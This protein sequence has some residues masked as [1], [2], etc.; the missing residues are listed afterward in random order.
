MYD[1]L[2]NSI[3]ELVEGEI[4]KISQ[5]I[6]TTD[7]HTGIESKAADNILKSYISDNNKEIRYIVD[8]GDGIDN[9]FMSDFPVD[10]RFVKNAQDEFDLYAQHWK[11]LNYLVPRAK[12]I[13]IPGNHDK[14]R[15]DK[16]KNMK[17]GLACL[18]NLQYESILKEAIR[19]Q[20]VKL[21]NFVFANQNYQIQ[22]TKSNLDTFAHG[23]PRLDP[24]VKCGITGPRRTAMEYPVQ[25][26]IYIGHGHQHI[27]FPRRQPGKHLVMIAGMFDIEQ[28]KKMY[29]SWHPYTNGFGVIKY[30]KKKDFYNFQYVPIVDNKAIIDGK[31]YQG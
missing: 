14:A 9:P 29:V 22:F 18:R 10:P 24:N 1:M 25:G 3:D 21:T 2:F 16:A 5:A 23:D 6:I 26:N 27:E 19:N 13:L 20:G 8:L 7:R 12:K 17:R 4:L 30:N 31:L 11:E 15:L 28:M